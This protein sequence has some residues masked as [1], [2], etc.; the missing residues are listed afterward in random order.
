MI[1]ELTLN[2]RVSDLLDD[3]DYATSPDKAVLIK[4][5]NGYVIGELNLANINNGEVLYLDTA[6]D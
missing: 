2:A 4:S 6:I 3:P 1:I 5:L